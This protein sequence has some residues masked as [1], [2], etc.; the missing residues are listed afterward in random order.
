MYGFLIGLFP[1]THAQS[2]RE[3]VE[4]PF[5]HSNVRRENQYCFGRPR[6]SF[7]TINLF[8]PVSSL[9]SQGTGSRRTA[10]PQLPPNFL[11]PDTSGKNSDKTEKPFSKCTGGTSDVAEL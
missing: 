11:E 7:E 8:L 1:F 10:R 4:P 9:L 5:S 2:L 3:I 6:F